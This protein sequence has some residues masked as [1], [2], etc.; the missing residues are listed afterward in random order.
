MLVMPHAKVAFRC[1]NCGRLHEAEHAGHNSVP[2]ACRVCGHGVVFSN[3]I[4]QALAHEH[5]TRHPRA[6]EAISR[7]TPTRAYKDGERIIDMSLPGATMYKVLVSENWEVLADATDERLAE[8]GAP[9]EH[10]CR[11]VPVPLK[12]SAEAKAAE[13]HAGEG[14]VAVDKIED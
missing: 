5:V 3:T 9:R 10:V 12:G 2:H 7:A 6:V 14:A 4:E 1:R 8:I 11:H 13:A